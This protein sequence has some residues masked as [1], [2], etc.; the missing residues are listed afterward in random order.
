MRN[1]L[2]L[3]SCAFARNVP[4]HNIKVIACITPQLLLR[5]YDRDFEYDYFGFKTLE[6]SYLLKMY[7]KVEERPQQ[8]TAVANNPHLAT[9]ALRLRSR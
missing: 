4:A 5:S 2:M 7:G 9:T 6:K 8:V 1:D 3:P